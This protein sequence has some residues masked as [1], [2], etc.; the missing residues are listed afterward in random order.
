MQMSYEGDRLRTLRGECGLTQEELAGRSGIDRD[1]IAKIETGARRM[2]A[3]DAAYLAQGLG[4]RSDDLVMRPQAQ[5][6][7]RV[8][9]SSPNS[10][11]VSAWFEDFV[12][13]ALYVERRLK[14]YEL[15]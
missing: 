3:T 5:V 2:S 11:R 4:V 9:G 14:R 7:W 1:K 15:E 12:D 13:D 6:H 10:G 8:S